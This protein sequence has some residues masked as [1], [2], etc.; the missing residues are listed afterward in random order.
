MDRRETQDKI[1]GVIPC[2]ITDVDNKM[3]LETIKMSELK[4]AMFGLGGD[5]ALGPNGF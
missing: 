1:L 4:V 5:K 2:I 3:L